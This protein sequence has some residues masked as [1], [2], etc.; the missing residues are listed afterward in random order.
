M[1]GGP[2]GLEY[3]KAH[4]P[5]KA[6]KEIMDFWRRQISSKGTEP[7]GKSLDP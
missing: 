3:L 7:G 2:K 5:A 6:T 4:P 1:T